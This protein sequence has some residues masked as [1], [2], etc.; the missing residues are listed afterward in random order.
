MVKQ[1]KVRAII[2]GKSNKCKNRR[3]VSKKL[4]VGGNKDEG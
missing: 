2:F 1:N 3:V 4:I